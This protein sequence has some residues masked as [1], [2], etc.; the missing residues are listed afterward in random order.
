[1]KSRIGIT[2][3][4]GRTHFKKGY[5]PWNKGLKGDRR[6]GGAPKGHSHGFK[7]GYKPWNKGKM[8]LF[9]WSEAE[10]LAIQKRQ[11]GECNSNWNGGTSGERQLA[12][13]KRDYI[14][15]RTAVFMRDNYTCQECGDKSSKDHRVTLNADH[16]KPWALY[17]DLR[18]AIDN[19]RTLCVDCHK[20]TDTW[21]RTTK[22]YKKQTQYTD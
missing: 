16:I 12:S 17:P 14:L 5:T 6:L 9:K 11:L 13:G 2:L 1:M 8:G 20:K 22:Y 21:G 19:G 10:K 18:Y 3:N 4:T 15:W 7:K